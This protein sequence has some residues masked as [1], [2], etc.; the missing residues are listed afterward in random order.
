MATRFTL[1]LQN[2]GEINFSLQ[3]DNRFPR[4]MLV[5]LLRCD[6]TLHLRIRTISE[7]INLDF[8]YG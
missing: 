5:A 6:A 4:K 1:W 8:L 7:S 3:K 2:Y